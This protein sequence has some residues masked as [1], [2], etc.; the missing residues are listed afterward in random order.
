MVRCCSAVSTSIL[1]S[2]IGTSRLTMMFNAKDFTLKQWV[3]T[4]P[5]GYDT[6]VALSNLDVKS[7]PDPNLFKIDYTDYRN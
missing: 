4:D 6:T 1:F 7:R 5:Q 2:G 3:V